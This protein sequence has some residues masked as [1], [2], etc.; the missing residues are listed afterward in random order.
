M[1][2]YDLEIISRTIPFSFLSEKVMEELFEHF[3]IREHKKG[4]TLFVQG[5]SKVD[6]F[7]VILK[8]SLERY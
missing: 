7:Y 4:T 5:E 2:Q 6:D 1:R 3:S 8:G